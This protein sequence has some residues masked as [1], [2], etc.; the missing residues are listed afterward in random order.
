GSAPAGSTVANAISDTGGEG[1]IIQN[2]PALTSGT[3]TQI[4]IDNVSL[5]NNN[6]TAIR[7]DGD[8]SNTQIFAGTGTGIVKNTGGSAIGVEGGSPTFAYVGGISNTNPADGSPSYLLS[9]HQTTSGSIQVGSNTASLVDTAN[10]IQL[11]ENTDSNIRVL[12]AQIASVGPQGLYAANNTNSGSSTLFEFL[13]I[14]IN[15]ATSAGVY[16][17]ANTQPMTFSNLNINLLSAGA[18]GFQSRNSTGIITTNLGNTIATASTTQPAVMIES[19][20]IEM[21]L[22]TVNS[23]LTNGGPVAALQFLTTSTGT[24]AIG[25]AF[26]VGGTKGTNLDV[27]NTSAVGV[28]LPP[29]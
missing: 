16:L 21:N 18:T 29:P 19:S 13:N 23:G 20:N 22:L 4:R 12:N 17:D 3:T 27:L 28:S 5:Q 15:A 9:V 8:A 25:Q 26:T 6:S 7:I 10:G 11:T 24:F 1:I 14:D 2:N